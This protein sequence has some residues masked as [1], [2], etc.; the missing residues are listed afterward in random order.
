MEPSVYPTKG[1]HKW[2]GGFSPSRIATLEAGDLR[3]LIGQLS[4]AAL[5]ARR[6]RE[7]DRHYYAMHLAGCMIRNGETPADVLAILKP[8]WEIKGALSREAE[9]DLE[10]IV[11]DTA[12][13]PRRGE[14]ASGGRKLAGWWIVSRIAC[15][16]GWE[17]AD[18]TEGRKNYTRADA[19]NAERFV[20]A[21]GEHVRYCYPWKCS[22][23]WDGSRWAKDDAGAVIKMARD[24]SEDP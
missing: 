4:A 7:G 24:G 12:E 3:R 16:L 18:K 8:A 10:E 15:A 2:V 21:Y 19:G 1:P 9:R 23:V 6:L 14:P 13:K 11:R 17:S 20:D 5:L 22:L